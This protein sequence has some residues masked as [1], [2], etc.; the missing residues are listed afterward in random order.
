V[1]LVSDAGLLDHVQ[2]QLLPVVASLEAHLQA[3]GDTEHANFV[4]TEKFGPTQKNEKQLI[5][6]KARAQSRRDTTKSPF[7]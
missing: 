1:D 7:M 4:V 6:K 3:S 2:A 5:F